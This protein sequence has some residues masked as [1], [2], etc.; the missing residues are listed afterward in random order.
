MRL[1]ATAKILVFILLFLISFN[2]V[3]QE[4]ETEQDTTETYKEGEII[5]PDASG[6]STK[7]E[8]DPVL[9]LYF[10]KKSLGETNIGLPLVLSTKEY[11]NL[12]LSKDI[13]DYF[14]QK[15]LAVSGRTDN[16]E[17]AQQDLLPNFYVNSR[18]F[19]SIFGGTNIDIIPQGSVGL[20]LGLLYTEQDNPAYSPTNRSN[21]TFDFDQRI[22]LS[23]LGRVGKR[24]GITANYD[25]ES[26]FDFQN[27]LKLEY[28]P[29][30]DDIIQ[31]IEVGNI[32]MPLNNS[33]IQG[34]QS[35]FGFKTELQFGKTR[36]TGVF[37]E[38]KSEQRTV[39]VEGGAA[40][41]DFETF[42]LG[43]DE[44][45][46]F[47]LAHYF[48]DNYTKFVANYPFVNSA[49]QIKRIQVWVTNRTNNVQNL[50]DTR[51]VIAIQDLGEA[52]TKNIGLSQ[53]PAGFLTQPSGSYPDNGS[54]KFNPLGIEGSVPSVLTSA[55]RDISTVENGFGTV[56]VSEGLDYAKL[57]NARQ[58]NANEYTLNSELGYISLN[59][60]LSNDEVLA[61]AFQYTV[62]GSVYQVGEF[63]NDG[64]AATGDE[65]QVQQGNI[66]ARVSKNLV[67]KMLKSS[68]TNVQ[69]P[70]WDL[71]MK[72]IY[73]LGAYDLD[74]D[75]FKLNILYTDPQPLNYIKPAEDGTP[76]PDDVKET[77]LLRVFNLDNLNSN[78]DPINEGDGFF[79]F[80]PGYTIDPK[81]G[82]V[83]FTSVEPFGEYLFN[84]LDNTPNNNSERYD[85]PN[86]WNSNQK[87]YVFRSLYRT[88]KT[89]AEQ[90]QAEK[91]KFQ[92][93]GRY[94]SANIDGIS[95]GYNVPRG[96]VT[97]TSGGRILQEG[98]DYVVN[99]EL[100]LVKVINDALLASD[101]PIQVTTE[102]NSLFG[103]QSKRFTGINVEHQFNQNLLV[104]GTFLN[105]REK[106]LTQK[107]NY[108]Y[109]PINNTI[110]GF[111]FNYSQEVP[112][113]TRLVNKLPN[114]DTDVKSN[115]SVRGEFAYLLPGSPNASDFN[116]ESTT[117]L[118]DFETAQTSIDISSP[119]SWE[120]SSV[121]IG[122]GGELANGDIKVGDK[123]AKLAWYTI[124]P[125]FYNN[126]RPSGISDADLSTYATRRVALNEIFPN[127]DISQGQ[128]QAIY[129]MDL[130]YY[131]SERGPYNY[132]QQ[133]LTDVVPQP[134]ANFGGI[135]KGINS[136]NFEQYNVEYIQFWV[137]DPFIYDNTNTGD[138]KVVF[139]L[140][141]ISEDVLKDGKKQYE[142]GLPPDGSSLN[143]EQT[144]LGKVPSDQSLVYAFD[145]DGQERF[146]Q[147]IGYDGLSD[148]EEAQRFPDF[149]NLDDPAADN[150]QYF[151]DKDG[152]ILER[153]KNYNGIDGN[154]PGTSSS[155]QGNTTLPTTEDI[156]RDN[157]MNTIDSYYQY[158]VPFFSGMNN[159]NNDY[160]ADVKELNVTM[161]NGKQ[162]PVRWLQFK[163][164]IYEPTKA[165]GGIADFRSIRFM[166]MFLTG[167][168][169]PT[170]FRFASMEMIR[171]DYRRYNG[172]LDE[173][174]NPN[175]QDYDAGFEVTAV[176]IEENEN[177][178]PIPYVL[179][180][181]VRREQLYQN[182]SNVRQNEQSLSMQVCGLQPQDAR[183]VYKNFQV[184]M[185]Q[186]KSLKMFLHGE[187]LVGQQKPKDGDLV[188]FI[189][190]GTDF[191]N[192][193]YQIEVPLTITA[194]GSVRAE[195][196]WPE[197]NELNI[198]LKLLQDV[199][200]AV[201]GDPSFKATDLN[202]FDE[203]MMPVAADD[204]YEVG[205]I[206][207]GI[208]GNPSFGNVRL[209]MLGIKNGTDPQDM[210]DICG[211]VWFDELR[212]ADMR[213]EGGWA[214]VLN[215][216]TNLADFATISATGSKSTV[217]F[218][219]LDQGPTQRSL[220]D[221]QSY[222][223][224]TNINMG[225]LLPQKWGLKI[226]VNYSR[227]EE[228]ITPLYDQE[229]L[230]IEL[231]S[232]L[233][234][235]V[236]S[237]ERDR[238]EK[239]SQTYTKRQSINLIGLRK[240]RVGEKKPQPYDIENLSV[241]ATYV[242]Q[243]YRDFEIEKSLDQDVGLAATYE[244]NFSPKTVE[245]F[246][247]IKA[248]DSGAYY[249]LF[250]DFNINLLP[251]N[252][253]VSSSINR[254]YNSQIFRSIELSESDIEIP[255]LYQRNFLFDWEYG[256]NYNL[257]KSLNFS[258]SASNNRIVRN[259]IDQQGNTDNTI[260]VWDG[261]FNTGEPNF[262]YQ[263]LQVNYQIPL[264]KLPV[265]EFVK[266]KYSYT[267]DFQW[268]RGSYV[269][270][271]LEDVP[272]IG[273]SVQNS[274]SHQITANF[275]LQKLYNY[276]GLKKKSN[277]NKTSIAERSKSMPSLRPPGS[278]AEQSA[279]KS[280]PTKKVKGN[281]VFNTAIDIVTAVKRLQLN[282][283]NNKGTF[284]PGYTQSIGFMGTLRPSAG[285]TFGLQDDI[286]YEAAKR[287]WLTTY[288]NFNQQYTTVENEQFSFQGSIALLPD[289][290]LDFNGEKLYSE[291]NS[292]NFRVDPVSLEYK[293]L[294]PYT[295]GNFSVSTI[296]LKTAFSQS[297]EE[298]SKNFE[299][300]RE[301]R[302]V[303][304]KRL[305]EERGLNP[306]DVGEDGYP[307]GLGKS[308]QAVLL[309]AFLAAYTGSD[310]K[311]TKLGAF[312]NI[313][314]P[315]WNLKYTGLM[316]IKW[317]KNNFRRF[318]LSHG[319]QS[320]Y[321][322]N[323]F[324]SNLDYDEN[325][326]NEVNQ[327]NNFKNP[328]LYSNIVLSELFTPLIQVD[329]ESN[330]NIQF[331]GR[332]EKDR[333]L[334]FSF[335]N[336]ILT[337][338]SGNE[339]TVGLGY[340]L[341]DLKI[342]TRLSG[343]NRI[344]SS[345]LN[346]KADVSYRRNKTIVR[347]LDLS[348][349][350]V[351]AGQDIW[352]INFVTD[353]AITRNLIA[354]FYYEHTFSEYAVSTA[355][356]QTTIRTGFSL[357]YNFGN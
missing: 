339:Y 288:Q 309:P 218:G 145:T 52:T 306:D 336:N 268:Q 207:V 41:Q 196:I 134:E 9:D 255:T 292:E 138:G 49:I 283:R 113:L 102:S 223:L 251:S 10:Y 55:I 219:S 28:T 137:M 191:T 275:D 129:T 186:Y 110:L 111:N 299:Q 21:L 235:I 8:Y 238:V 12:I 130:A 57:E 351:I 353:Y 95:I 256:L 248:I 305:A 131:P 214:G 348:N 240:E 151:L 312:R 204:E 166:R 337:E 104:S 6:I 324:Q 208:K 222:D 143:T 183:A 118:D 215:M 265:F 355:F 53:I 103:Q 109:E 64:V 75:N 261:F 294:T 315:N 132:N 291:T 133:A 236:D 213:N 285:F 116:G 221:V 331:L 65:S 284:L 168:N 35:L 100:G 296:M 307:R 14:K 237:K 263:T 88:T 25:T 322:I 212:L 313:P 200:S 178:E 258:F 280:K 93:K 185:R 340:R 76:L 297:D 87:K 198:K 43:Y 276:V 270:D 203:G 4:E 334:S 271:N 146:N 38:Q 338:I 269:Y 159:E 18:F 16:V 272:A 209:I 13:R 37:S 181:G 245:P 192:N 85:N 68:V 96:S 107:S 48:R 182:N 149:A 217:G 193:F 231:D 63:A 274:N 357:Q 71:M 344:L 101:T 125:S 224:V 225:Q 300:F 80:V 329:L 316:R 266:A 17:E 79:D 254:Q 117:Y 262:H 27:Q 257:T 67:V 33:L 148:A 326:P 320:T 99:Y 277:E 246:K 349:T 247:N 120:L 356:P 318:S 11:Q 279:T 281:K 50:T 165:I 190:I 278:P 97:V 260:D 195:E 172:I 188:A 26:T 139:N 332:V 197:N 242:Q 293:P 83:I 175:Q 123:R 47:F 243:D 154:S 90:E 15:N 45:R 62:N 342:A 127:T 267:G 287:G 289:L 92:L 84:K 44:N 205:R 220:E 5:L 89:Q 169:D 184:D 161:A 61:V 232:R 202:F 51:N 180:P 170:I 153:Y 31:N 327:A 173:D 19:E 7:Y 42:S 60:R 317:F 354:K 323:Q 128:S 122:F 241:S 40:V 124:D 86:T 282:Y 239:Q 30:E 210:K 58:L 347:Y 142:N 302:L 330:Y 301:N 3:A 74:P 303:V 136:T 244:F 157:T 206:R 32:S 199:K 308:N 112:F 311:D 94:K 228:L 310:A 167:F 155:K 163:I 144:N 298:S 1:S 56:R 119:L 259:Y 252:I 73:N 176:N 286:R 78:N 343:R 162:L 82:L 335:D 201:L 234:G 250:R 264:N 314:L 174:N 115:V 187:G 304:A 321:T 22:Q 72:N 325:N 141:N 77:S 229:Y 70:I 20:D 98:V 147:D 54:N 135:M 66:G 46:H 295:F 230:D 226:P 253:N 319:Y 140:G 249:S 81:N 156:N 216:D 24:L 352:S 121:P 328:T 350:Q 69:E 211:E 126:R 105:L 179:P 36:I 59:Q 152:D 39:N 29:T 2:G 177:R 341:K 114:I 227:G 164:P 108:G 189:R 290:T 158:E 34:A 91:N 160:I 194:D 273:N 345:D 150:Y 106:P 171:G 233:D 333:Q 346:F 23:L